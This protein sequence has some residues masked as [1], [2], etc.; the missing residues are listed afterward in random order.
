M[1]LPQSSRCKLRAALLAVPGNRAALYLFANQ[2]QKGST[3]V[4]K[5][6]T[7]FEKCACLYGAEVAKALIHKLIEITGSPYTMGELTRILAEA[8]TPTLHP[9]QSM[10]DAATDAAGMA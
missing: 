3:M 8:E 2:P 6:K 4:D 9:K 10:V 7:D 5:P 1:C